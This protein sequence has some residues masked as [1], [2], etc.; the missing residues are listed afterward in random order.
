[1]RTALLHGT[2]PSSRRE[3]SLEPSCSQDALQS[4]VLQEGLPN[5]LLISQTIPQTINAG[6]IL[7]YR[8]L[9]DY[10]PEKLLVIGSPAHHEASVLNCRYETMQAPLERLERT[11]LARLTA[12][13]KVL[14]LFP[15]LS[16]RTIRRHVGQFEPEVVLSIMQTHAYY[17]VAFRFAQ[18]AGLPL[19]IVV[20]DVPEDFERVYGFLQSVQRRKNARVY[21]YATKRLCVSPEMNRS[22][23]HAYGVPGHVLYPN[24]SE[25]L[26]PRPAS[27]E[28]FGL[29]EPGYLTVGYAGSLAYGYGAQLTRM[30]PA[31]REA[32][33]KLRIYSSGELAVEANDIVT[34]CGRLPLA[35]KTWSKVKE[36]CDAVILPYCWPKD[37]HQALYRVHFPSKLSEYLALGMPVIVLGP[38][39]ATGVKWAKEFQA[40]LTITEDDQALWIKALTLLQGSACLR[41]ELSKQALAAAKLFD[42]SEIRNQFLSHLHEAAFA[43]FNSC[44]EESIKN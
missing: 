27:D 35:E 19:V 1:M 31:F 25:D 14:G 13:L 12:S 10:P 30:I 32:H 33:V 2:S 4:A 6:D 7:L 37:G 36:E 20:Y 17:D 38:E 15:R 8:L 26:I 23:H 24:R 39:Y 5:L 21:T 18:S 42:P 3:Y 9:K 16:Q 44:V 43:R 41:R 28:P 40:A 29:K 22:L 11:R 34:Y